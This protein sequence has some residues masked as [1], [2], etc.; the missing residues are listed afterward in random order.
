MPHSLMT[1][2]HWSRIIYFYG[3]MIPHIRSGWVCK[4]DDETTG[5]GSNRATCTS[6]SSRA[7]CSWTSRYG[8]W[9]SSS[10]LRSIRVESIGLG[11]TIWSTRWS[12]STCLWSSPWCMDR[13]IFGWK[14]ETSCS[15]KR[16]QV[17]CYYSA[18]GVFRTGVRLVC[19]DQHV[20]C[21]H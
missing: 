10:N 14:R 21:M 8:S 7:I 17:I 18:G 20:V 11:V 5:I 6:C 2:Q 1:P 12:L 13:F 9:R 19:L 15:R 3:K 16:R 4:R